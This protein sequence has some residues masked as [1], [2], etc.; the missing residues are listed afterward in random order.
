MSEQFW[1]GVPL[2][3]IALVLL[4]F[5]VSE[6]VRANRNGGRGWPL[7]WGVLSA[8]FLL[9]L[10]FVAGSGAF[11]VF[12]RRTPDVYELWTVRAELWLA[13][14]VSVWELWRWWHPRGEE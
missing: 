5:G 6:W 14:G 9:S 4:L 7:S 11:R 1:S 2:A 8:M 10:S 13:F 12:S 3:G